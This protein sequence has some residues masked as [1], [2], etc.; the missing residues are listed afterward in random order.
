ME[1]NV[2]AGPPRAGV[3]AMSLLGGCEVALDAGRDG[4]DDPVAPL[5]ALEVLDV[6]RITH[7]TEL[8]Q[9]RG[10]VRRLQNEEVRLADREAAQRHRRLHSFYNVAC[11][12]IGLLPHL[13]SHQV[14]KDVGYCRL[15]VGWQVSRDDV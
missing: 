7:E 9:H 6:G 13:P 4:A 8:D 14:D 10:D 15:G 5:L 3:A 2:P 1:K 12:Q 11:G